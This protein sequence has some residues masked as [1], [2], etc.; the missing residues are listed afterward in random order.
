MYAVDPAPAQDVA[1]HVV[2]MT[3]LGGVALVAGW[4]AERAVDTGFPAARD[5]PARRPALV[6]AM[7]TAPEGLVPPEPLV[8]PDLHEPALL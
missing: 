6:G 7:L 5:R 3:Q 1:D 8:A 2:R 4:M